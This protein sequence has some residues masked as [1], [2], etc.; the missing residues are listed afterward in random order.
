MDYKVGSFTQRG[1][2]KV[3]QKKSKKINKGVGCHFRSS[4]NCDV[5]NCN[6][7]FHRSK[8]FG[9]CKQEYSRYNLAATL[10]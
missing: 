9:E 6:G 2:L 8:L 1:R 4:A 7:K 3:I 5:T 10:F